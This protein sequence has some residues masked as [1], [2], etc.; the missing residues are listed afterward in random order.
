MSS[1][2]SIYS[3][4]PAGT[5]G[6]IRRKPKP[7]RP[8]REINQLF[9]LLFF[10]VLPVVM[11]LGVFFQPMRWA[12]L[13]LTLISL[14][15]M[16]LCQAFLPAGRVLVTGIYGLMF[17]IMMVTALSGG[18]RRD[19]Y[20]EGVFVSPTPQVTTTPIYSS[21]VSVS[22]TDVPLDYYST[23]DNVD[24][25]FSGYAEVGV[26]TGAQ[27]E[28]S[29]EPD[30]AEAGSSVY[31]PTVK[32][33][34]E[35]VLEE[36][37]ERWRKGVIADLLDCTAPSWR[38]QYKETEAKQELFWKFSTRTL[39]EWHQV[40]APSGTDSSTARTITIQAEI[41]SNGATRLL[42]M[43]VLTLAEE[44]KWYVDPASLSNGIPV[45]AATPTPDPNLTPTPSPEPTPTPLPGKKTK[46]YYNKDGG[47]MYH[48]D[49]NCPSVASKYRPLK[50]TFTYGDINKSPY[51]KLK[52]CEKCG[53]PK[54]P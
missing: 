4:A 31:V 50:G 49:P 9:L 46:L 3:S 1:G 20:A 19:P 43:D 23:D 15:A 35:T 11:L 2:R 52:P 13:A 28:V 34:S 37:M 51:S 38:S 54:R 8:K 29:A 21:Y 10:I 33:E 39:N 7:R 25:A 6:A 47:K 53:A 41:T 24:D 26:Q 12:F 22:S 5:P 48:S 32:T 40:A 45:E 17:V 36:F 44:G 30:P 27:D 42:Q 16:W 18:G 14:L